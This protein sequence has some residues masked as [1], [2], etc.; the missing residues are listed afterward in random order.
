MVDLNLWVVTL[1]GEKATL[2]AARE[3]L[4]IGRVKWLQHPRGLGA[5]S[6]FR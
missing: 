2:S 3:H 6:G 4:N 5:E 1:G